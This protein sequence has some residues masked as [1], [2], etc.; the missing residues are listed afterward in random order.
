[1]AAEDM[2]VILKYIYGVLDA[3]PEERLYSLIL[4]ADRLQVQFIVS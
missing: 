4:E 2:E 1:M 3:L